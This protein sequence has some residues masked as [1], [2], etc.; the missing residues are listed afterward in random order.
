[1]ALPT[2][3]STHAKDALAR[4]LRGNF[5][6]LWVPPVGAVVDVLIR[7]PL[8][9]PLTSEHL[10]GIYLG[11]GV[12]A[13]FG[14]LMGAVWLLILGV[15]VLFGLNLVRANHPLIAAA[16]GGCLMHWLY[17]GHATHTAIGAIAALVAAVY[18]RS[19]PVL[20]RTATPPAERER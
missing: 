17:Y 20:Q 14:A 13:L 10:F 4:A 11:L 7:A 12:A 1:M 2:I 15:P 5:K 6:A 16:A 3:A 8:Y 9:G 19:N 18:A